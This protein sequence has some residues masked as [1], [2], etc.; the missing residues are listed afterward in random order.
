MA[1]YDARAGTLFG[2]ED[3]VLILVAPL[4][5]ASLAAANTIRLGVRLSDVARAADGTRDSA[6][7]RFSRFAALALKRWA[8]FGT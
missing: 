8:R 5:I 6:S 4:A 7:L 1:R 3:T 2:R